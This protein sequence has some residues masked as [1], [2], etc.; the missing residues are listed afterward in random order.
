MHY[1]YNVWISSNNNPVLWAITSCDKSF[2]FKL[3]SSRNMRLAVQSK[4]MY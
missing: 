3:A 2:F 1:E 4:R